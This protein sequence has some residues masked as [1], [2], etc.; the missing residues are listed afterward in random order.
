MHHSSCKIG[1]LWQ[2]DV[3]FPLSMSWRFW[4]NKIDKLPAMFSFEKKINSSLQV[5][6]N[7]VVLG[8]SKVISEGVHHICMGMWMWKGASSPQMELYVQDI[9][10]FP[11]C[12]YNFL[13]DT[14]NLNWRIGN[15]FEEAKKD[16]LPAR[17]IPNASTLMITKHHKITAEKI[18]QKWRIME[19]QTE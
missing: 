18:I 3:Y 9:Q 7:M 15:Y 10:C 13:V 5:L 14:T 4:M 12:R 1:W 19:Y 17:K 8:K 6:G 11:D 16:K 2:V